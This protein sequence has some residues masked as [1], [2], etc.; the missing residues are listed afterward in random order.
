MPRHKS[1]KTELEALFE[2]RT[3]IASEVSNYLNLIHQAKVRDIKSMNGLL[4]QLI[5]SCLI[6]IGLKEGFASK[7]NVLGVTVTYRDFYSCLFLIFYSYILS[8]IIR[9][10]LHVQDLKSMHKTILS[11]NHEDNCM[12]QLDDK[13]LPPQAGRYEETNA[14]LFNKKNFASTIFFGLCYVGIIAFFLFLI[15]EVALY[16][17]RHS[18]KLNLYLKYFSLAIAGLM[19]LGSVV[20]LFNHIR[21]I[22]KK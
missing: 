4:I 7:V 6:F 22:S 11:A 16:Q 18:V 19:T 10:I 15:K 21:L 13:L 12:R 20:N 9:L 5:V 3:S 14:L 17:P 8:D 1:L 2:N